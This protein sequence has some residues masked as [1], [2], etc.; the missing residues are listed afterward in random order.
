MTTALEA[1]EL[2]RLRAGVATACRVLAAEGLVSDILGHVS[3]R[4]GTD[5]MLVRSRSPE[6]P[7]LLLS[8]PQD[9]V[10]TDFDGTPAEELVDRQLPQ[11]LPI[12][13]EMLR[14][15]ADD[16]AVVHAHPPDVVL[17]SIADLALQPIFGAFNIPAMHMAERGLPVYD[18]YGLVRSRQRGEEMVKAMDGGRA[19]LLRGHGLTTAAPTLAGAVVT[20]LNVNLLARMTAALASTGRRAPL[21]PEAD[22]AELPDLGAGFND[23][24]VWRHHVAKLASRGLA[25]CPDPAAPSPV[26]G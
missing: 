2:D 17:C 1:G 16:G 23:E 25:V 9:V 4:V 8:R 22:R 11:E 19:V 3:V 15:R 18:Y 21:V 24:L 14:A 5:R 20:A 12:H 26:T 6:D 13:G 7:G 10:L